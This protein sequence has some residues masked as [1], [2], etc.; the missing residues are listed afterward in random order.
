MPNKA[1]ITAERSDGILFRRLWVVIILF[2]PLVCIFPV[3]SGQGPSWEV[4]DEHFEFIFDESSKEI[5]VGPGNP[6]MVTFRGTVRIITQ[7]P[8]GRQVVVNLKAEMKHDPDSP[9][10]KGSWDPAFAPSILYF[11]PTML[12][13]AVSMTVLCHQFENKG[14]TFNIN[15]GGTYQVNPGPSGVIE[16]PHVLQVTAAQY[17]RSRVTSPETF[18]TGYPGERRQFTIEIK[19]DGT[20][21]DSFQVEFENIGS[22]TKAGFV[23]EYNSLET[24]DILPEETA[25]YTFWVT[26]PEKHSIWKSGI[27][28]ID[29][30][31]SSEGGGNTGRPDEM[32]YT[33]FYQEKGTYYDTELCLGVM[34]LPLILLPIF[35]F[36]I[37]GFRKW[38]EYNS[39]VREFEQEFDD[40]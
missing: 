14:V 7:I 32:R 26:G 24:E 9:T 31:I 4:T 21:L 1:E 33:V 18:N 39:F 34:L 10:P 35:C 40:E 5:K 17:F 16:S 23:I 36:C 28:D 38:E 29:L 37:W 12:E 20:G 25:N 30:V 13:N 8:Q 15:I 2:L 11:D 27:H 22:L 3:G 6:C 19:N